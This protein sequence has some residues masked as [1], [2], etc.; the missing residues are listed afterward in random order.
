VTQLPKELCKEVNE[1][2]GERSL[3]GRKM[4]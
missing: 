3:E 4:D 2:E 1:K